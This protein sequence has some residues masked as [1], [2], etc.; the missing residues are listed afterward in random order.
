VT[1]AEFHAAN[2]ER[3]RR[4][5]HSMLTTATHD[6]KR[7]EDARA[8]LVALAEMTD[9]WQHAVIEWRSLLAAPSAALND[10][11]IEYF[12]YQLLIG[13]WPAVET[14][15]AIE[16]LRPRVWAA[17]LKSVREAKVRTSWAAPDEDYECGLR[18]FI[19]GAFDH[20]ALR[21]ALAPV[22]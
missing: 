3:A 13:R 20:S 10:A 17:M 21:S 7:G 1:P 16:G 4:W 15:E 6:T 22:L 2:A 9:E 5:P 18:T 11:N 12:F 14:P 8:R 19:D